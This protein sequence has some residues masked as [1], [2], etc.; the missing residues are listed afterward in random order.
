[1]LILDILACGFLAMFY[2]LTNTDKLNALVEKMNIAKYV[3]DK[4][5]INIIGMG[6][7]GFVTL[8]SLIGVIANFNALIFIDLILALASLGGFVV[9]YILK[10]A[11]QT[12]VETEE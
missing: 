8:L 1:M 11:K 7:G 6:V 12:T 5:L 3:E 4:K 10:Y 2:L 9:L